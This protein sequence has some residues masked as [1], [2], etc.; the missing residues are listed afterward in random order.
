[1]GPRFRTLSLT[2]EYF[3]T[4]KA[5][6]RL[7]F[8][9]FSLFLETWYQQQLVKKMLRKGSYNFF[10][11]QQQNCSLIVELSKFQFQ[12]WFKLRSFPIYFPDAP[13]WNPDNAFLLSWV[14]SSFCSSGMSN[15]FWRKHASEFS[16]QEG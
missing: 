12:N 6:C 14:C 1:M 4:K 10:R 16:K 8:F 7:H 5:R 15:M 9:L 2:L 13:G 3:Q 11:K